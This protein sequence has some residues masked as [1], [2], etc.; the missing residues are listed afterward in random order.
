MAK[1]K[2]ELPNDLI[3]QFEKLEINTPQMLEEMTRA[4]AKVVEDL[5]RAKMPKALYEALEER[6]VRLSRTYRTPS[7]DGVNTQVMISGYFTNRY[8]QKTPAPLVANMFE[9]GSSHNKKYPKKPFLRVSFKPEAITKA[10]MKV[11]DKYL[12]GEE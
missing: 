3:K 2:V 7:D 12:R 1:F 9:Y 11:Q 4:G 6:D 8:G 10:M 5:V